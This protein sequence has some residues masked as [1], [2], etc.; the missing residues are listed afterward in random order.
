LIVPLPRSS[1]PSEA[2]LPSARARAIDG[3]LINGRFLS[4]PLAGVDRTAIEIVSALA[5]LVDPESLEIVC[6]VPNGAPP[7]DE[8]R[9]MLG[10]QR[11]A[12]I[13]RSR[14]RGYLW[15]Q[16]VLPHIRPNSILLS[17]C[18]MGPVARTNQLVMIHDAQVHDSPQSYSLAFRTA[19]R[20]LQPA[21]ARNAGAVATVSNHSRQRMRAHGIG[22]DRGIEVIQNGADHMARI[23]SDPAILGRL[24]LRPD[25]YLLALAHPALHKNTAMVIEACLQ[26]KDQAFPLVLSGRVDESIILLANRAHDGA[27]LLAGRTTDGELKALYENARLFL[28]PSI[29]EGFGLPVL[30]AMHCGC[31]VITSNGGAL[32]EIAGDAAILCDPLDKEAWCREIDELQNDPHRLAEL[33]GRGRV[34]ASKFTWRRSAETLLSIL[35]D[36]HGPTPQRLN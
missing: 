22:R 5:S 21:L 28:L 4:R 13:H 31:P 27:V 7:D 16:L 20:T 6:A 15:E 32:P 24:G 9:S 34:Q 33:S 25:G 19:Y 35:S 17:L 14:Y 10:L 11:S 8:I 18:N 36:R 12:P 23:R 3:L 1:R 26:R 30:E 2:R 29:T